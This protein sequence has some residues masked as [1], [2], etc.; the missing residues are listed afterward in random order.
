MRAPI[1]A[2]TFLVVNALAIPGMLLE[3]DVTAVVPRS[4]QVEGQNLAI[5][6]AR[7]NNDID[8]L[9]ELAANFGSPSR[10]HRLASPVPTAPQKIRRLQREALRAAND[11]PLCRENS[12]GCRK[13]SPGSVRSPAWS[14]PAPAP[15]A[16][17]PIL[18][19]GKA[20]EFHQACH[21]QQPCLGCSQIRTCNEIRVR[22]GK[23]FRAAAAH[24]G[25]RQSAEHRTR[26]KLGACG[27]C[28]CAI[29]NW[30]STIRPAS[31][32]MPSLCS[33]KAMRSS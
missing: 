27:R 21:Q 25:D 24:T 13:S 11:A 14:P 18:G 28:R 1:P 3:I 20:A 6:F 19:D 8:R 7:A 22:I 23:S 4:E 12:S 26:G 31:L 9:P 32:P 17:V 15:F 2:N 5:E 30:P 10:G 29:R 33:I 16:V